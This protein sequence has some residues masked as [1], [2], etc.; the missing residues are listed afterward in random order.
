MMQDKNIKKMTKEIASISQLNIDSKLNHSVSNEFLN[1]FG[2]RPL[3]QVLEYLRIYK[4]ELKLE[5]T[6]RDLLRLQLGRRE[7]KRLI[8]MIK[9]L[10]TV[11]PLHR[12]TPDQAH[13][14]YYMAE[15]KLK[16]FHE[17]DFDSPVTHQGEEFSLLDI[18]PEDVDLKIEDEVTVIQTAVRE[19]LQ[20]THKRRRK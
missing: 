1:Y 18:D 17:D 20:K 9:G 4:P 13:N 10:L 3:T 2:E 6:E 5:C 7:A 12:L 14:I 8:G 19:F 16:S 15:R 11:N